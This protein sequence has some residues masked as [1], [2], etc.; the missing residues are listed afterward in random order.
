MSLRKDVIKLAKE[1]PELRKHLLPILKEAYNPFFD[2]KPDKIPEEWLVKFEK[3]I[4]KW[5]HTFDA[6]RDKEMIK[7]HRED[8]K[9]LTKGLNMLR[10]GKY[11]EARRHF[12][13]LDTVVR[14]LVPDNIWDYLHE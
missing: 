7:V 3:V 6:D 2:K 10:A 12:E 13:Y 4:D 1:K 8:A 14:E 5:R 11:E 9:D